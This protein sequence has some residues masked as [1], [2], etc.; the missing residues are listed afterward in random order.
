MSTLPNA[1]KEARWHIGAAEPTVFCNARDIYQDGTIPMARDA[2]NG[3]WALSGHTHMGHIGMFHGTCLADL[4]EAWPIR[5]EF[6]TGGAPGAFDGVRY[7]EGILPRGSIWPFGLYI[8]PGT[9]RF[10]CFF[11]NET[12][13]NGQGTGYVIN[14][15]GDG[16]P[17]FRHIGLMHSDDCGRTWAFDRWV[18]TSREVCFSRRY[19]PDGVPVLGQPEGITCLGCGDFSLFDDPFSDYLY[20]FY[21]LLNYDPDADR[22]VDCHAYVARTRK[23]TDGVMG[24]FVKYCDGAFCEAGNL[25]DESPIAAAA[26]HPRVVYSDVLGCYVLSSC[27]ADGSVPDNKL[28]EDRMELRTSTDLLHWSSPLSLPYQNGWFGNHYTA[29]VPEDTGSPCRI[30]GRAFSLLACHNGTDVLR[31]AAEFEL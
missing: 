14:G 30:A 4:T 26:W 10:F 3:L 5:T 6:C 21:D 1:F 2:Q 24:D 27:Y 22:W 23:R 25:G 11:H 31:Y 9:N 20:L 18:L 29:L 7:P 16:E 12:G 28:V 8:C 19:N 13:W 15:K 17:D